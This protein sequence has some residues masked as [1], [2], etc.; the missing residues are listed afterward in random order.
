MPFIN[1]SPL[2]Y[3][4]T[5]QEIETHWRQAN[6]S[7]SGNP[8]TL[9]GGY[10]LTQFQAEIASFSTK[11][12]Q[13]RAE[14]LQRDM[15]AGQRNA[16]KLLIRDYL[17]RFRA[18]VTNYLMGTPYASNL[19][20][21]P[22]LTADET[23]YKE[24]FLKMQER[25][26]VIDGLGSSVTDFTAPLVLG[27][28]T[29]LSQFTDQLA[30]LDSAYRAIDRTDTLLE[31]LRRERDALMPALKDRATQ[32][33]NALIDRFGKTHPLVQS[34]PALSPSANSNLKAVKLTGTW[35]A[36]TGRAALTWSASS[37]SETTYSV[38]TTGS[39]PYKAEDEEVI[40]TL[41]HG[42]THFHTDTGLAM[43]GA[44]ANFKVYVV[45]P[46]GNERGSNAVK[47]VRAG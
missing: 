32:Y 13:T 19:P 37:L 4:R 28:G 22:V 24:P 16:Q 6:A 40:A 23:D 15:A 30:D 29:T 25:W 7:N 17:T 5:V 46:G 18:A 42:T 1:R 2:A 34:L 26:R 11:I 20:T 35:D 12:D 8:I 43:T 38:R 41:P 47:V 31:T 36:S 3:L 14:R 45:T 9:K 10:T 27:N 44:E 33:K 21:L 39:L